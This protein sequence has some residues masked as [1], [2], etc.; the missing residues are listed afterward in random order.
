M[1]WFYIS[2][3]YFAAVQCPALQQP[4]HSILSCEGDAEIRF[5]YG[6]ACSFSCAPG[7]RLLGPSRVVC[8]AAAEWSE[9]AAHC[10]GKRTISVKSN[11]FLCNQE[12]SLVNVF[13]FC[14]FYFPAS[15]IACKFPEAEAPIIT[16]CSKPLTELGLNSSCSFSCEPGF[17]LQGANTTTCT[18]NGHW[19]EATP[20]CKGT[21]KAFCLAL[22]VAVLKMCAR[23]ASRQRCVATK[24]FSL[25][26]HL[27]PPSNSC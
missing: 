10:E 22:C 21:V 16:K 4:D 25:N 2:I 18:E 3:F 6:K 24:R 7:Y 27:F 20:T 15:V 14:L 12:D 9:Q 5:S 23:S 13:C 26:M 17:E 11:N 19:N 8:T 1:Y